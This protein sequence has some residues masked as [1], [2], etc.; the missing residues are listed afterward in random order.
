M[1]PNEL[2]KEPSDE[3]ARSMTGNVLKCGEW[4]MSFGPQE[5][6]QTCGKINYAGRIVCR[7]CDRYD[8]EEAIPAEATVS[9]WQPIETAPKDGRAVFLLSKAYTVG[10][11]QY[12]GS[13][14]ADVHYPARVAIGCWNPEGESWVDE[15]GSLDG[16]AYTLAVTGTW[17]SGAAWFQ[18]NEV[19]HWMPL[20]A[21]PTPQ[22]S[23]E[24]DG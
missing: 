15:L 3:V 12:A 10:K 6:C 2:Q 20:P 9:E 23:D 13:V 7:K 8:D 19:T 21:L 11:D 16:D 17:T 4:R 14:D 1:I 5:I 22:P 24:V 18:P